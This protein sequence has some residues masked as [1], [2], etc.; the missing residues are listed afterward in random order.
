MRIEFKPWRP[1]YAK[2][3]N[4]GVKGWLARIGQEAEQI[5]K[6]GMGHYPPA[7]TPSQYPARRTSRLYASVSHQVAR[8]SVTIGS[9]MFY[10]IFLRMGTYKMARRK[11]SDD[12]LREALRK[13]R[14]GPFVEW[15]R[16]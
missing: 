4:V 7:S 12:A 3:R 9:N 16:L 2:Y 8:D 11:M 6:G 14:L 5:F 15:V 10:S 1:F 13:A